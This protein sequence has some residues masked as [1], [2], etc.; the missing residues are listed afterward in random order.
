MIV[1][2]NNSNIPPALYFGFPRN[3]FIGIAYRVEPGNQISEF[4]YY[5]MTRDLAFDIINKKI[6]FKHEDLQSLNIGVDDPVLK[7]LQPIKNTREFKF[8]IAE[9]A[10]QAFSEVLTDY[11]M[12]N[13]KENIADEHHQNAFNNATTVATSIIHLSQELFK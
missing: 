7:G 9:K 1:E 2:H 8:M 4:E 12:Q 10:L 3:D 5:G 11:A 6:A 13:S